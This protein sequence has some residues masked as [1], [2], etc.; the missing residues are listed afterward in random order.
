MENYYLNLEIYR[1][2]NEKNKSDE[3]TND[4]KR[5]SGFLLFL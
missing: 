5:S 4:K 1:K 2:K 3:N